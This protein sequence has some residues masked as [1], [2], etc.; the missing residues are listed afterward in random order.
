MKTSKTVLPGAGLT[1]LLV[2]ATVFGLPA[3]NADDS[4]YRVFC[5]NGKIEVEQRTLE[6]EKNARGSSVCQL[7]EFDYLSDAE[8]E[9]EKRGGKGA[10]CKCN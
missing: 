7:A 8:K 6:Q 2:F 10:D 5:A 9:A 1:L 4:K 3:R